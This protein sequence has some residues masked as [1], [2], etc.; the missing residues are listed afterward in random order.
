MSDSSF[1]EIKIPVLHNLYKKQRECYWLPHE[2][3]MT[4]DVNDWKYKLNESERH[5]ISTILAF[6]AGS[7]ILVIDNISKRFSSDVDHI[8]DASR[9]YDFQKVIENIHSESY[10]IMLETLVVDN[11]KRHLLQNAIKNHP[12]IKMK[13]DWVTKW[14]ESNKNYIYRLLAFIIVEGIFFSS[15]FCAI[16]WFREKNLLPGISKF[17][18]FISRDEGL[19]TDFGITMIKLLEKGTINLKNEQFKKISQKEIHQLFKEAVDIEKKFIDSLFNDKS[20]LIGINSKSM[21]QYVEVVTNNILENLN[22]QPLYPNV[23]NPFIFMDKLSVNG[24]TNFF[25]EDVTEY[26]KNLVNDIENSSFF[27]NDY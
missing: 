17:N 7:D 4:K 18:E 14:I 23:K 2:V 3:S 5:L 13:A 12:T 6:F 27:E 19:H 24:K 25:E 26:S 20:D 21:K 15:S 10:A 9:C 1:F 11:K 22:Y 8:P 16:Y